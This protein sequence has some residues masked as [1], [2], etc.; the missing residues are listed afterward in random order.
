MRTRKLL[1]TLSI[2]ILFAT[3]LNAKKKIEGNPDQ[4]ANRMIINLQKTIV[5]TDSQ[6]IKIK[7]LTI[8]YVN[9]VNDA[10]G[11]QVKLIC[12]KHKADLDSL[13]TLNQKE[14]LFQLKKQRIEMSKNKK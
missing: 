2:V 11:E 7:A 12:L 1:L 10:E 14:Q 5:L 4:I 9:Q 8:D 13:L 3:I 6:Q